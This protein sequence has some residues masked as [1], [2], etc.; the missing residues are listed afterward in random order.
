MVRKKYVWKNNPVNNQINLSIGSAMKYF[1]RTEKC[2]SQW[3][4]GKNYWRIEVKI[5]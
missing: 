4:R 1:K 3:T 5:K 2:K